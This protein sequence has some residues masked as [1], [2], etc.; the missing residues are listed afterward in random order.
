L[1]F[2]H[3]SNGLGQVFDTTSATGRRYKASSSLSEEEDPSLS[4]DNEEM[5]IT[6]L[7][8]LEVSDVERGISSKEGF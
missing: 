7:F 4:E 2:P 5:L 1:G 8:M 3:S 6:L